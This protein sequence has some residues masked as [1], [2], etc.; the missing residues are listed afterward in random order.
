MPNE[1]PNTDPLPEITG[2]TRNVVRVA[3]IQLAY[4]AAARGSLADPFGVADPEGTQP[5]STLP[6]GASPPSTLTKA[7]QE[8]SDRI[9]QAYLAQLV[10]KLRALLTTCREWG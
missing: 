9:E 4:H 7:H 1:L 10:L 8:L 2:S 5:R 3:V 6:R